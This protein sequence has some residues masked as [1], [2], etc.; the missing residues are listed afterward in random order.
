MTALW[1]CATANQRRFSSSRKSYGR[2]FITALQLDVRPPR[3]RAAQQD[4]HGMLGA[5]PE[6][7][8]H[9]VW[10]H[11]LNSGDDEQKASRTSR[12]LARR[13]G[14]YQDEQKASWKSR[15]LA[16]RAGGYQDE[17]KASWKSRRL[18]G[19][20]GGYQDEQK[21]SRTSRRLAGRA[22]GWQD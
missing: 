20:A 8:A 15:R 4:L 21:A 14:G 5:R 9:P 7:G 1:F 10:R 11:I 22:G 17:Q 19:R 6:G 3:H 12:R 2:K 16:G 13:A 18:A